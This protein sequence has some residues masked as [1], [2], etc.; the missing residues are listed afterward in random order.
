MLSNFQHEAAALVLRL[1]C[2]Q[3]CG[4]RAVELHV[5][6]SSGYLPYA[7]NSSIAHLSIPQNLSKFPEFAGRSG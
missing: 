5:D 1:K 4:K 3:D 7:A 6:D 2:I